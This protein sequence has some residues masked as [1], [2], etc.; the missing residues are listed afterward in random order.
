MRPTT[1]GDMDKAIK[2][3]RVNPDLIIFRP[4]NPYIPHLVELDYKLVREAFD[5]IVKKL[6]IV[7]CGV[8]EFTACE[9][10][11]FMFLK[12]HVEYGIH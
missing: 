1:L 5:D 6:P 7:E 11:M 12:N 8:D 10:L 9:K 3:N 4:G 2:P